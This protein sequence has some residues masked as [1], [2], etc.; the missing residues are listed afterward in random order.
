MGREEDRCRLHHHE[1]YCS[2][3]N[4]IWFT[5]DCSCCDHSAKSKFKTSNTWVEAG[6]SLDGRE[7][8]TEES[9]GFLLWTGIIPHIR[10][11]SPWLTWFT[12][13]WVLITFVTTQGSITQRLDDLDVLLG[14][15]HV[16]W[17]GLQL[18]V[19][20]PQRRMDKTQPAWMQ[21]HCGWGCCNTQWHYPKKK[22][23]RWTVFQKPVSTGS[24]AS[25]SQKKAPFSGRGFHH[26]SL[27][28]TG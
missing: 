7:S 5:G 1:I 21:F 14:L 13:G 28:R 10:R 9:D 18:S 2:I 15:I 6:S 25:L 19:H 3:A 17:V 16:V 27:F 12:Q 20:E 22:E 24:I 8:A 26:T 23:E 11:Q 4:Q